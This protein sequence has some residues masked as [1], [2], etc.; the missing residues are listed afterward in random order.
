MHNGYAVIDFETTGLSPAH[1]HRIIEIGI[2]HVSPDGFIYRSVFKTL[3]NVRGGPRV[4]PQAL[5]VAR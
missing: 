2:V 4:R 5:D 1:G 3:Q